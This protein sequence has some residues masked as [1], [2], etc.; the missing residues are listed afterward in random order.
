MRLQEIKLLQVELSSKCNA[1]CP[2]CPR[3]NRG[4]GLRPG[5]D[6]QDLNPELLK[7]AILKLPNLARVQLCGRFGD[8]I[9]HKDLGELVEWIVGQGKEINIHTNGSL[10]TTK[11]WSDLG[12]LLKNHPHNIWF[13]IDGLS[14]VHEIYRQGTDFNKVIANSEAFVQAGGIATWQF[15]PFKHNEHQLS[16][17]V[18]LAN[19]IGFKHFEI[20]AGARNV[21]TAYN[22]RTNDP[23]EIEEWSKTTQLNFRYAENKELGVE[24]CVHLKAP[25]LYISASG[26]FTMCCHFDSIVDGCESILFDTIEETETLDINNEITS[27]PRPL[28]V[29]SCSGLNIERKTMPLIRTNKCL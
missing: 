11:W 24:N 3:N 17:C 27:N 12:K 9:M 2:G 28:C 10:R 20:I 6:P 23:Y 1:W 22:Y 13:A 15:I 26:K 16:D 7:E 21:Y 14:G 25:A 4:Y 19:K 5:L 18:K 29:K 8:P